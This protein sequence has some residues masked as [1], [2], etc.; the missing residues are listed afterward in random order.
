MG[1]RITSPRA[2][3]KERQARL[4]R[5]SQHDV[6]GL[7]TSAYH[8]GQHGVPTLTLSFIH[9]CGY[10]TFS[11]EVEDDVLPCYGTIQLLHK[12][13]KTAWHNPRTLQ[14]GPSVERILEKG[15]MVFPKLRGTSAREAVTFYESVQQVSAAYLLPLMPFDSIC[16]ANNY[17]GL[18]PPGL[19]TDA[20]S[21]C[22]IAMLELLHRL[23]P[24][25][26]H[27]V[28]VKISGVGNVSR[29]GYD[30]LWRILELF[31]PGFNP[32]IP[33]AQPI[34]SADSTILDFCHGHLLYFCLQTKKNMF[35]SSRD[36]TTI[37][38]RAIVPSEYADV[39]T[40]LQTS[41]DAYCHP[42][43]DG[44]LPDHLRI[45]GIASLIH[46]SI[47]MQN[48]AYGTFIRRISTKLRAW[49]LPGII[50][51]RMNLPSVTY[52]ATVRRRSDLNRI[53]VT[54]APP[55]TQTVAAPAATDPDLHVWTP[56]KDTSL[57][58]INDNVHSNL[59]FN[60]THASVSGTMLSIATCWRWRSISISTLNGSCPT[61]IG[62]MLNHGGSQS[63]RTSLATRH[64]PHDRS[65]GLIVRTSTS[66]LTTSI[67]L[68][69]GNA[70]L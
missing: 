18:F 61:R 33:I 4:R 40:T 17:E 31:V 2:A 23:L 25:N 26:D 34:W 5:I 65:C 48:I 53:N 24:A 7:A 59:G 47:T 44:I 70:G 20:Y 36:R 19:G 42:D 10:Q 38:L 29:N 16:L 50:L 28:R 39:V 69:T 12:K 49:T 35:F 32:T 54:T 22:C 3:D 11:P 46:N 64:A 52:R 67:K 63:G 51:T 68:W 8:G 41:V 66:P 9:A 45:N 13:V 21:E 37:F 56:H 15:L 60:A 62:P 6:A 43:N 57:D 1:G 58:Q 30:L 27:E 55:A 14:S